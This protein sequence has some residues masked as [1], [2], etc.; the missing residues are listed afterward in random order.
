MV[1]EVGPDVAADLLDREVG[2]QQLALS[3]VSM[4]EARQR[5]GGDMIRRWTSAA[6]DWRSMATTARVVVPRT[7]ESSTTTSRLPSMFSR[8]GLS[9]IRTAM[10][11]ISWLGAMNV[12]PMYRF[13]TS[14]SP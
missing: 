3:P 5:W 13:F 2:R 9:F 7:M 1:R 14:P 4:P 6:P 12:R 10:S 11:R 8:S